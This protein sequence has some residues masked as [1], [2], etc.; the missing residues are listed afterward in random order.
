MMSRKTTNLRAFFVRGVVRAALGKLSEL[1]Y[2]SVG[3]A[4]VSVGVSLLSATNRRE[5]TCETVICR[6][7]H[8]ASVLGSPSLW[9]V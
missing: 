3:V 9:T 8:T 5:V 2:I 6:E 4:Q 1:K 7:L